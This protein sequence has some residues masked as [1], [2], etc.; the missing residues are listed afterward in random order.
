MYGIGEHSTSSPAPWRIMFIVCGAF[1]AACGVLFYFVMPNSPETAWFLTQEERF[2][3]SRRLASE[4]D[5]GDKTNFSMGQLKEAALDFKSYAAFAFGILVTAPS[6]V[7][8]VRILSI[9]IIESLRLISRIVCLTNDQATGLHFWKYIALWIPIRRSADCCNLGWYH[10]LHDVS[11]PTLP[12]GNRTDYRSTDRLHHA[13]STAT[14]RVAHHCRSLVR[15]LHIQ[16]LLTHNE[17]ERFK[18]SG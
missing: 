4:H 5:G 10:S 3:A 12:R 13:S 17:S 2:A 11:K 16:Y 18:R 7:L 6:P 1:T 15:K 8:T 9:K 14:Q